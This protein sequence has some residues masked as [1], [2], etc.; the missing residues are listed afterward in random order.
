MTLVAVYAIAVA[1]VSLVLLGCG[2]T[3]WRAPRA[4]AH[5]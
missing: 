2:W 3:V 4:D 5:H 1:A